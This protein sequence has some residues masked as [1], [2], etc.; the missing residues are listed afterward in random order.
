MA[1]ASTQFMKKEWDIAYLKGCYKEFGEIEK[2][3]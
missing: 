3:K 1:E 2:E